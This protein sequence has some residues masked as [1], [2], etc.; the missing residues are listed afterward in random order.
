MM[1]RFLLMPAV[2]AGTVVALKLLVD[3]E[4]LQNSAPAQVRPILESS[5][6]RILL[7][8]GVAYSTTTNWQASVLAV[9]AVVYVTRNA[10]DKF[11][12]QNFFGTTSRNKDA[13]ENVA[14]GTAETTES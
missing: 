9:V 14:S 4:A 10:P 6:A 7:C 5:A 13:D 11:P 1:R 12:F 2:V 3:F 8:Y